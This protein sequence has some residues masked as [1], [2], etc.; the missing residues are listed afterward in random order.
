MRLRRLAERWSD[1]VVALNHA[2]LEEQVALGLAPRE[3]YVVIPNGIDLRL[4]R[5]EMNLTGRDGVR[6]SLGLSNGALTV[7]VIG[8]LTREKGHEV[9]LEA[10]S[11]LAPDLSPVLL[12]VGGGPREPHLRLECRRLGIRSRVRFLGVRRDV[13]GLLA[14]SDLVVLPSFYESGG[15]VLMEAMAAR[16]PVIASRTGGVPDLVEDGETGLLVPPGE[17][18]AL[19]LAMEQVLRN[20]SLA[21]RIAQGGER[22]VIRDH[23]IERSASILQ[24]LYNQLAQERGLT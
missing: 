5:E 13:P 14:A 2:D 12:I 18:E 3:K 6:R 1:R 19:A 20:R 15:L 10:L 16:R 7:A 22:K 23:D 9:L 21:E 8:R 4:F 24:D 17:P 11:R